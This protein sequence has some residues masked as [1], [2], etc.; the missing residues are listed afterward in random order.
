MTSDV[1]ILAAAFLGGVLI[2]VLF[3]GGL[4]LLF[5]LGIGHEKRFAASS[6]AVRLVFG[7]FLGR[8]ALA[9]AGLYLA[10]RLGGFTGLMLALLGFTC[11]QLVVLRLATKRPAR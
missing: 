5:G 3:F 2:G 7:S 10:V 4:F 8:S 11:V 9:L 6:H 1:L